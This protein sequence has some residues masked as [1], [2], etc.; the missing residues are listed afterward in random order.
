MLLSEKLLQ[1]IWLHR[2]F[3]TGDLETTKK[4]KLQIISPGR[5]NKDSGPDFLDARIKVD[6]VIMAGNIELHLHASDWIRHGH[7]Q[8]K[9]Y[10]N[11]ILHVINEF[12]LTDE[13][14]LPAHVPTLE[15]KERIPGVILQRYAQLMEHDGNILCSG[16]L[17]E[18][19]GLTWFNWKDRLLIE[20]WQHKTDLFSN[21]MKD[22]QNNWEETFYK[23]LSRNFGAPVNGEAFESLA[24]SLPLKVIAIHKHHLLQTEA[25]LFGQAGMLDQKFREDYPKQLQREYLFLQKKYHLS[26]INAGLWKWMRMRPSNFP[27]I[28]L[29]QLAVLINQS[30]HLFSRIMETKSLKEVYNMFNIHASP[31]WDSHYHF[32][33]LNEKQKDEQPLPEKKKH[34][35]KNMIENIL[36]NTICPMLAMYDRFQ[37]HGTY[38]DRAFQWMRSLPSENN[39]YTREWEQEGIA[40]TSAWDSQSLLQLTKNYCMEKRCLECAVGNKILRKES[41]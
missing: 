19:D 38:L 17:E 31:Y 8:N 36:I 32:I 23:A 10:H 15:L 34:L 33:K 26:S 40:N 29:A 6:D 9:D 4:E 14:E 22:S 2:L 21:W 16:Q 37:M 18:I 3:N 28:R 30:S 13:G 25:L 20:R 5:W 27:T 24:C 11:L 1:Y 35:G 7:H 41:T 39:R 12:D